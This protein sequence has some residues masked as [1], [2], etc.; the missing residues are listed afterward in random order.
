MPDQVLSQDILVLEG[1]NGGRDL[2]TTDP[3]GCLDVLKKVVENMTEGDRLFLCGDLIDRGPESLGTIRYLN[4]QIKNRKNIHIVRGNHEDMALEAIE[5]A[6]SMQSLI[7]KYRRNKFANEFFKTARWY[8][9]AK[10][11][12]ADLEKIVLAFFKKQSPPLEEKQK[13]L[14]WRYTQQFIRNG[15]GWIFSLNE[16]EL[17]EVEDFIKP[18]PYMIRVEKTEAASGFDIV[19]AA[20]LSEKAIKKVLN[21]TEKKFSEEQKEYITWARPNK[22]VPNGRTE[23]DNPVYVGHNALQQAESAVYQKANIVNLD[24]LTAETGVM[25]VAD[26]TNKNVMVFDSSGVVAPSNLK[27]EEIK[28]SVEILSFAMMKAKTPAQLDEELK[29]YCVDFEPGSKQ[30]K[31]QYLTLLEEVIRNNY[32][33]N[34]QRV[35][36]ANYLLSEKTHPLAKE[37]DYS[38]T[39]NCLYFWQRS[40]EYSHKTRSMGKAIGMLLKGINTDDASN[41]QQSLSKMKR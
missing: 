16:D 21:T 41:I 27:D 23:Q 17:K 18:L 26:H 35:A 29:K 1:N 5:V 8:D 37:K 10:H 32:I 20:P 15:A 9:C 33:K 14:Y 28:S 22:I 6:R 25:C 31:T 11:S 13:E 7:L 19:H 39:K 34:D 2:I 30:F 38:A 4:K 3:H 24:V 36:F 40:S 12:S